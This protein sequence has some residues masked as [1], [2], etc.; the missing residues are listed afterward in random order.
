M[1]SNDPQ[2]PARILIVEDNGRL[3]E[4]LTEAFN[5][6]G[7]QATGAPDLSSA[8]EL[9]KQGLHDCVLLDLNLP[10]GAGYEL[11]REL[12]EGTLRASGRSLSDLPVLILS[13]RS[14]EHDR[15]RGFERGC[16]DYVVKPFSFGEL[17][18]RIAAVMRRQLLPSEFGVIDLDELVID[19][20]TRAVEL[21]GRRI[22]LTDKEY[23]LLVALSADPV[24][25]F[26]RDKL[27]SRI[28]GYGPGSSTR[29]LDSHACRLRAKLSGGQRRYVQNCWGVGYRLLAPVEA[30]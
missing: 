29:T 25:V 15:I 21:L 22:E 19:T 4:R 14:Q 17:R 24:R 1:S 11:L 26:E 13:G 10:D 5:L 16:D 18:G 7:H 27:L 20:H 8:R 23:S 28:W 12:R 6:D 3:R 30:D 9:L 2:K